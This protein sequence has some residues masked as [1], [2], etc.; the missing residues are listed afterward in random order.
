MKTDNLGQKIRIAREASG[1]TQEELAKEIGV[2]PP[3]V[4]RWETGAFRPRPETIQKL[5]AILGRKTDWLLGIDASNNDEVRK[6][7]KEIAKKHER[8][9]ENKVKTMMSGQEFFADE[10]RELLRENRELRKKREASPQE[11]ELL[12]LWRKADDIVREDVISLLSDAGP[13]AARR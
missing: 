7:F 11:A 2:E 6:E 10:I 13:R 9:N 1:I 3:T 4:S 12:R 5:A 8:L